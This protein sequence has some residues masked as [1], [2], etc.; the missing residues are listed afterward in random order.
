[1]ALI[2]LQNI[3][4][5]FNGPPVLDNV[6]LQ[7]EKNQRICLLGRNGT[8]KSTLM[9]ILNSQIKPD[10][11][12]IVKE[13]SVR[14]SYFTQDIPDNLPGTV[15]E[16]IAQGLGKRGQFLI[17]YHEAVQSGS[18]E[19]EL[20][21]IYDEL[22][23]H[24]GWSVSEEINKITT[25]MSLEKNWIYNNLSGGQKR[26]V[27]LAAALVIEPDLLLLD[28]PTNHLDIDS[29]IWMEEFLLRLNSS[30]LFV[31]HDRTLLRKLATRIIELDRGSLVDWSCDYETFLIRKQAVL[32]AQEKEWKKFDRKLAEEEVWIRKGIRA[33]RTRNEG[34]V[35]DL[36][37]LREERKKRR[38]V[39]GSTS[40]K[41]V[42][43]QKSGKLAIKAQNVNYSIDSKNL[44]T[45]L[46]LTIERG[47]KIGIIGPNGCGKSTLLKILLGKLESDSGTIKHGTNLEITYFDQLREQLDEKKTVMENVLPHSETVII[48]GKGR[49]IISYLQDFLFTPD[50]AKSY[51]SCLSGGERNRLLLAKLFTKSSNFLAL[52]EPTNDLDTET[53]EL[54]EEILTEFKGTLLLICHDRSFINN[55]VTSTLAFQNNGHIKEIIG[56]YDE[57][58][59]FTT[60]QL[61]KYENINKAKKKQQYEERKKESAKKKLTFKQTRELETLPE[62]IEKMETEKEELF[63]KMSLPDFYTDTDN[64][65]KSKIRLDELESKLEIAY[66]RWEELES[67]V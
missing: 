47:D 2:S 13:Q 57:W 63:Q 41:I 25:L 9:K 50:Q 32:K 29:I 30:I 22:D 23:K 39:E 11:G 21:K 42:D 59:T 15:F 1:M 43:S 18:T 54:L 3:T 27:I 61:E 28:E 14:I 53:L 20:T 5:A 7:I 56:G 65:K 51:V 66:N 52:D 24:D 44:I 38:E 6:S 58:L 8:G 4:M 55:V 37:M 45:D 10:S 67:M 26:R 12:D 46:D 40:M 16:I 17:S 33:R 36:K 62:L 19:E 60:K 35:R 31:T 49:H 34:R 64:A 48:N